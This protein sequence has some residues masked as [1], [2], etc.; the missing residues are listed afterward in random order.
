MQ[1]TNKHLSTLEK[2]YEAIQAVTAIVADTLGPEGL[3]V[4]LIDEFANAFCTNDGVTILTKLQIKNPVAKYIRDA[5]LAQEEKVGDGTTSVCVVLEAL[6]KESINTL[7]NKDISTIRLTKLLHQAKQRILELIAKQ[8]IAVEKLDDE[9]LFA[10][11]AIASREDLQLSKL[12]Q[13][14][15]IKSFSNTKQEKFD[16]SEHIYAY[17]NT[18][19]HI[20]PGFIIKKKPHLNSKEKIKDCEILMVK[21]S[22]EPQAISSEAASTDEGVKKFNN[23][24]QELVELCKKIKK[25]DIKA[26]FCSGSIFHQAEEILN[27][28]GIIVLSHLTDS[29]FR[30]IEKA[31]KAIACSRTE[32]FDQDQNCF[33]N[34]LGKIKSLEFNERFQAFVL[35]AE[36]FAFHSLILG[37]STQNLLDEKLRI[38]QDATKVFYATLKEG[39]SKGGGILELDILNTLKKEA[40]NQ[41]IIEIL[42]AGLSSI[43]LQI[44]KNTG[45]QMTPADL[46]KKFTEENILDAS[47]VKKTIIEIAFDLCSQIIKVK[48]VVIAN[49]Y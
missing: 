6:L 40:E 4:M 22:L 49:S 2:N 10:A 17:K 24:V 19:D 38:A 3:N 30:N 9:K 41:E 27:K 21:G 16:L 42:E 13:Q 23:N 44:Q 26:V 11:T 43:F 47:L 18:H 31:S 46:E 39:L 1:T 20:L 35:E 25:R 36:A 29:C 5:A 8:S 34:K 32:L 15:Y 28:E 37:E 48:N 33:N 12:I 7:R 14:L 45:W